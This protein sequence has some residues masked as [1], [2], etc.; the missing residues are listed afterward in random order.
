MTGKLD[1]LQDPKRPALFM[2][3]AEDETPAEIALRKLACWLGVGGFNAPRVDAEQFH[4][5][6]VAAIQELDRQP[7]AP[8]PQAAEPICFDSFVRAKRWRTD[9]YEHDAID[10]VRAGHLAGWIAGMKAAPQAPAAQPLPDASV[11]P[12]CEVVLSTDPT[13]KAGWQG[14]RWAKNA[15]PILPGLKLYAHPQP[16]HPAADAGK[17]K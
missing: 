1:P 8:A 2:N 15:P 14:V 9:G 12:I 4:D 7:V 11:E 3:Y 5:K 13:G 17:E 6:I 10:M 16:A